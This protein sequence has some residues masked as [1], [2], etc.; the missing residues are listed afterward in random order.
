[1]KAR[2]WLNRGEVTYVMGLYK[3][4]GF[5]RSFGMQCYRGGFH[6]TIPLRIALGVWSTRNKGVYGDLLVFWKH[7]KGTKNWQSF[8]WRLQTSTSQRFTPHQV[9]KTPLFISNRFFFYENPCAIWAKL[10]KKRKRKK[11]SPQRKKI[12]LV[13]KSSFEENGQQTT[14]SNSNKAGTIVLSVSTATDPES[15]QNSKGGKRELKRVLGTI[16]TSRG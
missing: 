5:G 8:F 10:K 14:D 13:S 9:Q 3:G 15:E 2:W 16:R 7:Q 6:H 1:M 11:L 4:N 12:F